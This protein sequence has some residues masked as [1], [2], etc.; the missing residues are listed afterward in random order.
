M[1]LRCSITVAL[2]RPKGWDPGNPYFLVLLYIRSPPH[3]CDFKW[4]SVTAS[5][6]RA[7]G[8]G[9]EAGT[10]FSIRL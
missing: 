8:S 7:V 4:F 3:P 2:T 1:R 5:A 6:L 9:K 10:F